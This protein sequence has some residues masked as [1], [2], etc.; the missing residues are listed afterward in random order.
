MNRILSF[1]TGAVFALAV[2]A[3]AAPVTARES[4]P[5]PVVHIT[6]MPTAA[7]PP[8]PVPATN[9]PKMEPA[10]NPITA[11][12]ALGL[13]SQVQCWNCVPFEVTVKLSSYDPMTGPDSC[14]D[15]E[16]NNGYCYS[17]TFPGVHW[18][19]VWGLTAACPFAW[20]LGTWVV[21]PDVLTVICMDRGG[22]INCENGICRV[23]VLGPGG[24]YWNQQEYKA[25]IWVPLDP[26]RGE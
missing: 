9:P 3:L 19:G 8:A 2:V 18:K 16:E 26:Q 23:D 21:V 11:V 15:Y 24:A 7:E 25:V 1:I 12:G 17:P 5:A 10:M 14:W 4:L 6:P 20:T 22:R 13:T